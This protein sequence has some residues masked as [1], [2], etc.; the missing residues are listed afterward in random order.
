VAKELNHWRD[1]RV[2]PP[3]APAHAAAVVADNAGLFAVDPAWRKANAAGRRPVRPPD[4][5][6]RLTTVEDS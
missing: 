1:T 5:T 4:T 6:V 2:L 3:P